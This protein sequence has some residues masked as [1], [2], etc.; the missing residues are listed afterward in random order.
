MLQCS[1]NSDPVALSAMLSKPVD[2]YA[3]KTHTSTFRKGREGWEGRAEVGLDGARH[4]VVSTHKAHGGIVTYIQAV[5]FD[6]AGCYSYVMFQDFNKRIPYMG[7]RCTE[8]TIT[9]H[10]NAVMSDIEDYRALVLDFYA[11]QAK[12]ND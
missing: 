8:K 2:P 4:L 11:A 10:H 3:G 7:I 1:V 9:T 5:K 6:D 12:R